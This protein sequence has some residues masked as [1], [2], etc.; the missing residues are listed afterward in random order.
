M[1]FA[2]VIK[3]EN[4]KIYIGHSANLQ[5]RMARHNNVLGSKKKSYTYKN[6]KGE[7]KLIYVEEFDARK[8]AIKR[9]KQLKL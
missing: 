1:F 6:K 2:Y 7:W 5:D 8:D 3:N 4:N 9:E